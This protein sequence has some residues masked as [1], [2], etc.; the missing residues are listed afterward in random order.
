MAWSQAFQPYRHS[1]PA[2]W[3]K[4]NY[5][6]VIIHIVEAGSHEI[7]SSLTEDVFSRNSL[8]QTDLT[9]IVAWVEKDLFVL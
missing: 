3:Q 9:K 8:W 2:T 4:I 5:S 7:Y 1:L 6:A